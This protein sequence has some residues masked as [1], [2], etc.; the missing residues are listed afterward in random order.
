M[1]LDISDIMEM[2]PHR[3]PFL[4]IDRVVELSDE[5]DRIVVIKNVT[6]NE[7]QFTGH[8]PHVPVMPGVLMIEAMAQACAIMALKR[9]PEDVDR[10]NCLFYFAGIDNA[11]FKRVVQPGD[12]LVI[13]GRFVRQKMGLGVFEATASVDGKVACSAT[14]MCAYR[15]VPNKK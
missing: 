5:L 8:F 4:L 15:P 12:Q 1:Q 2:L 11:R 3:Y 6:A 7:P 13:E 9:L 14:L 10:E